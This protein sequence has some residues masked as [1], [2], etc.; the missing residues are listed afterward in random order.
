MK[1]SFFPKS[2]AGKW[3]VFCLLAAIALIALFFAILAIFNVKGGDTF[4]SNPELFIPLLSAWGTGAA[5]F[6]LGAI[7]L[8]R[9]KSKSVLVFLCAAIGFIVGLYGVLEVAFP[10]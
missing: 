7:S 6:V 8:I 4:F 5:S 10:H 2:K 1:I 3:S 9:D